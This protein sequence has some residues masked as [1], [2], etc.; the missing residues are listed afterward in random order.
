MSRDFY[1]ILAAFSLATVVVQYWAFDRVTT[2]FIE[3]FETL[4]VQAA[5]NGGWVQLEVE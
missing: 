3:R 2:R 1:I 4:E 5:Q